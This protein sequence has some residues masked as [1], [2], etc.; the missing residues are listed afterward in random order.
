MISPEYNLIKQEVYGNNL[1]GLMSNDAIK[2][3]IGKS[4]I[5]WHWCAESVA[6]S[7]CQIFNIFL[8]NS[9]NKQVLRVKTCVKI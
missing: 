4:T 9:S 1:K 8:K 5:G 7:S 3:P 2:I 6:R